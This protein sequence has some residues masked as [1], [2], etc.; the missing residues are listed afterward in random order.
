MYG[1]FAFLSEPQFFITHR[2]LD[3][4]NLHVLLS[5]NTNLIRHDCALGDAHFF[6]VQ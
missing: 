2:L 6:V 3:F 4:S 5:S 1:N